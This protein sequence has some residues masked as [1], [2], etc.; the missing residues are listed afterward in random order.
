M[1]GTVL[2][3]T[4]ASHSVV[5]EKVVSAF[6]LVPTS[7]TEV[8]T[9]GHAT[10]EIAL[11][12]RL[13]IGVETEPGHTGLDVRLLEDVSVIGG[14]DLGSIDCLLGQDLLKGAMLFH[15]GLAGTF[16]LSF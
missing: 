12:Y 1:S 15:N 16:T 14:L 8:T 9:P 3:D 10:P 13:T 5:N 11:L 7:A 4:G 2:I 6:G